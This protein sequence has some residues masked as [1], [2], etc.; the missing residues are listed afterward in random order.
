MRRYVNATFRLLAREGWTEDAVE[1]VNTI[2]GGTGGPLAWDDRRIP[3]SLSTHLADIYP[4]ELDKVLALPE[5]SSQV[6]FFY[7]TQCPCIEVR[8]DE[9]SHLVRSFTYSNR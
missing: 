9:C 7:F 1:A 4:E 5:V 8:A 6:R 3:M 2:M